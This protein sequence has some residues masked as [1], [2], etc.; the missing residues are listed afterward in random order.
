MTIRPSKEINTCE[1]YA[2]HERGFS[3]IEVSVAIVIIGLISLPIFRALQHEAVRESFAETRGLLAETETGINQHYASVGEA[4]PCPASLAAGPGDA[5]YGFSGDCTLNNII[6]CNNPTWISDPGNVTDG[7]AGICKTSNSESNAVIIGAFPF[8]TAKINQ[9]SGLDYWDN[10]IIYAVPIRNTDI[11]PDNNFQGILS[12]GFD[13]TGTIVPYP[14]AEV[15]LFSTGAKGVGGFTKSGDLIENCGNSNDGY[16]SENC[17]FDNLFFEMNNAF[18]TVAGETYYDDVVRLQRTY[19]IATW[20]EHED[21]FTTNTNRFAIT[22]SDRIGI[23]TV[24]PEASLHVNG[25]IRVDTFTQ[26]D[27]T[28][29]GGR[30]NA[31]QICTENADCFNPEDVTSS[32]GAFRCD[33]GGAMFGDQAILSLKKGSDLY[34]VNCTTVTDAGGVEIDGKAFGIDTAVVIES[35]CQLGQIATGIDATGALICTLPP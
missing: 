26:A 20:F 9:E 29:A 14:P 10:K 28:V 27:G 33:A 6:Q 32:F 12:Q 5:N 19:P 34:G 25:S 1:G 8:A 35:E 24:N 22:S 21:N 16:E 18:S 11:D 15:V 31:S 23:G 4:Y 7:N 2:H 3:L 17:D 30:L 13:G